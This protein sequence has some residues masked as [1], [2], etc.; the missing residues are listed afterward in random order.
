MHHFNNSVSGKMENITVSANVAGR[1]EEITVESGR[2]VVP[3][4]M[5]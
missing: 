5:V 2:M 1:M 4:G 3:T